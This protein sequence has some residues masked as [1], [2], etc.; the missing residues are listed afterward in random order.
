MPIAISIK[1]GTYSMD[2]V[3]GINPHKASHTAVAVGDDEVELARLKDR[4]T[5]DVLVGEL[6]AGDERLDADRQLVAIV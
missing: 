1:L 4:S 6:D 2:V 3:I 5:I